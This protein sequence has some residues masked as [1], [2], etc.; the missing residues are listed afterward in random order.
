MPKRK[1]PEA[2]HLL[3]NAVSSRLREV[4]VLVQPN[5]AKCAR[6]MKVETQTWNGYENEKSTVMPPP[7]VMVK[8]CNFYGVTMDWLYRGLLSSQVEA[9]VAAA[10]GAAH[11]ERFREVAPREE[12]KEPAS[13][14]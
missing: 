1:L 14:E 7:H 13:S 3:R 10:L 9:D 2:A 8:F 12:A 5:Q 6:A 4:R 11:P